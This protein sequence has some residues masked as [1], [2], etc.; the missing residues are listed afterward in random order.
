MYMYMYRYLYFMWLEFLSIPI[1]SR[2]SDR[3]QPLIIEWINTVSQVCLNI[4]T[5]VYRNDETPV[6]HSYP[7]SSYESHL[8]EHL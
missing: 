5:I 7:T 6:T 8:Y 1:Q 2:F 4:I 3:K